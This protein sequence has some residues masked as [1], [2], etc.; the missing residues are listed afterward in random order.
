MENAKHNSMDIMV[1]NRNKRAC[2]VVMLISMK[3]SILDLNIL[4]AV[5]DE[6][7]VKNNLPG[8]VGSFLLLGGRGQDQQTQLVYGPTSNPR[9]SLGGQHN[10]GS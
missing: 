7:R 3:M 8:N 5:I 1:K 9:L 2:R 10:P 4:I 6:W